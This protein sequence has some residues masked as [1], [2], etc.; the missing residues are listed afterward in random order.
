M[1]KRFLSIFILTL[2]DLGYIYD[3]A[4][5]TE[6]VKALKPYLGKTC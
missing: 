6:V 1:M 3:N 2:S 5:A 4:F